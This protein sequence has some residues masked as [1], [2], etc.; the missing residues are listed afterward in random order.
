MFLSDLSLAWRPK[1][2]SGLPSAMENSLRHFSST[3]APYKSCNR[4][5]FFLPDQP[6]ELTPLV[7]ILPFLESVK[8]ERERGGCGGA[9]AS[10]PMV[11]QLHN[12]A[13]L[14]SEQLAAVKA[15]VIPFLVRCSH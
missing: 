13:A 12:F 4:Q 5:A 1:S 7:V 15:Q 2:L 8:S 3:F 11:I 6:A 14:A 10:T 9:A